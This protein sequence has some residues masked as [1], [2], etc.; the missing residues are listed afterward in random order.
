MTF[1]RQPV[2]TS[3][4]L[5]LRPLE[6]VDFEG[7]YAAASD[8]ETWA[9]HP[10]KNRHESSVFRGYYDFLLGTGSTLVVEDRKARQIIG[11]SRYY[12]APDMPESIA[13]GFTFLNHQYWGGAWNF[14]MKLLMLGH[15][16]VS[17]DEVWFH[18]DPTNIRSQKATGKLGAQH[19]YD[20]TLDL[21]SGPAPWKCYKL[22]RANWAEREQS[23]SRQ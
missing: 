9:G 23:I 13:I 22:T 7:L 21:G 18:I 2:L 15:A 12:T 8:P 10:A 6:A 19:E 3:E 16:F 11:C 20:A 17:F 5:V 14:Q 1:D 4:T